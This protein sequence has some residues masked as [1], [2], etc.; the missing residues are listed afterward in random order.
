[1]NYGMI[2]T[3]DIA[4]G[5]GVRVSLFVSGCRNHCEGCFQPE[6][7]DFTYGSAFDEKAARQILEAVKPA[8]IAGFTVLG[9]EPFEQENQPE[10]CGILRR[11][12]EECPDKTLW[13]YTGYTLDG[14]LAPGGAKYTEH[15]QEILQL[16]DVLV[17]GRFVQEQKDV[18]LL[19][20][21][22]RN[23]RVID[24]RK[25]REAG[26]IVLWDTEEAHR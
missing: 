24:M 19:F 18:T 5:V 15:T 1:M 14:E 6:T 26:E 2:K 10:V 4:N 25:T 17:D 16:L 8:Y 7:W 12:R 13:A 23:Q 20:R 11:I 21:G 3:T 22:S 9:G